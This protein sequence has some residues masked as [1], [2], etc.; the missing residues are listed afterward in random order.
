MPAEMTT[1]TP[2][3]G[4]SSFAAALGDLRSSDA[5]GQS[6]TGAEDGSLPP[7]RPVADVGVPEVVVPSSPHE[8]VQRTIATSSGASNPSY[9]QPS[10][11]MPPLPVVSRSVAGGPGPSTEPRTASDVPLIGA[12][13]LTG[14]SSFVAALGQPSDHSDHADHSGT[15]HAEDLPVVSRTVA[16]P[17]SVQRITLPVAP[18]HLLWP[19]RRVV[20]RSRG[21]SSERP[22]TVPYESSPTPDA[23]AVQR[24]SYYNPPV[25]RSGAQTITQAPAQPKQVVAAE[26]PTPVPRPALRP[27]THEPRETVRA[28]PLQRMFGDLTTTGSGDPVQTV[29]EWQVPVQRDAIPT[30]AAI[31]TAIPT[32]SPVGPEIPAT[33]VV[34]MAEASSAAPAASTTAPGAPQG[35]G[36][37]G[38]VDV[39]E[40]A[41]RL[42]EPLTARLRAEL[43]LDRERAGLVTDRWR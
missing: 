21:L 5:T 12:T 2:L 4:E 40:M 28:L 30:A 10:V 29:T 26:Q 43:W 17:E 38:G 32:A 11:P 25:Q 42:Y 16:G 22:L 3:I 37:A 23:P 19:Q 13:D 35:A 27:E 1:Q 24:I 6:T 7:V 9:D 33:P 18:P 34:Q 20:Q 39:D 14:P 36:G 15:A 31:P 41:K 8:V